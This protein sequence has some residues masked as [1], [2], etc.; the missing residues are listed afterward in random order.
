MGYFGRIT[1]GLFSRVDDLVARVE[2]HEGLAEA[3]LTELQSATARGRARLARV[4]KDERP[5]RTSIARYIGTCVKAACHIAV[6]TTRH[7][8]WIAEQHVHV[9]AVMHDRIAARVRT[10][11][12]AMSERGAHALK[13]S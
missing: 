1:S 5:G 6:L 8:A 7:G 3:A 10:S 2:N 11:A 9:K 4:Q 13:V 12:R